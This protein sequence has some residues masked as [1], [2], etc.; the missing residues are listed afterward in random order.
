MDITHQGIITLL[1]SAITGACLSLP[2]GFSLESADSIIQ[3]HSLLA[4]A[5]QG[6]ANCGID[7]ASEIMRRYQLQYYRG[8]LRSE[9]Q[10][11]KLTQL[12][13]AFEE[14]GIDYLPVKGCNLKKMY[15]QPEMRVMGD[16]DILIRPGQKKEISAAM[17]ALGFTFQ[18]ENEHVYEWK[19]DALFV[20]L[21][22]SLVPPEDEDFFRYYGTG[23][24][25]AVHTGGHRYD[26][27]A[28]DSF[29][30]LFVH[31]ARHYRFSGIGCRQ[32]LDL[33]VYRRAFPDLRQ[34]YLAQ[35]LKKLKLSEFFQNTMH[36][37]DVWFENAEPDE[38]SDLMTAYIF[39]GGSWGSAEAMLYSQQ[40]KKASQQGA[41]HHSGIQ[42]FWRILFPSR[43]RM[44]Y[45]YPVLL[46]SPYLLPFV[47]V[48]RWFH[49]LFLRPQNIRKNLT[50]L[51]SMDDQKVLSRQQAMQ[52]V[53]LDYYLDCD[54]AQ[55]ES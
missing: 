22:K 43:T 32:I 6:A 51:H 54:S 10:M 27:S 45:S 31:F 18:T 36:L 8:I 29:L 42:A 28:E 13:Q 50:I 24:D 37:L 12:F 41:V 33:W 25:L 16:A 30:F 11:R 44:C 35:E 4:L 52:A 5:C 9:R 49:I 17:N 7:T 40:L 55:E 19:C 21:H 20:E 14:R 47:W 15:P 53:G 23:W 3:S 1:K 39:S 46:H 26:L 48:V 2:D 34:D 38:I